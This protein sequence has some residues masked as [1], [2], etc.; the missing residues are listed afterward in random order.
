MP[1]PKKLAA[2]AHMQA[3]FVADVLAMETPPLAKMRRVER[4]L[5]AEN[6]AWRDR[7]KRQGGH[8][9]TVTFSP[10]AWDYVQRRRDMGYSR[11][12]QL[13]CEALLN[14]V[15]VLPGARAAIDSLRGQI[16]GDPTDAQV[17]SLATR[18][19]VKHLA[20]S[21]ENTLQI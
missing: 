15:E 10:A 17:V 21:Q 5:I 12:S 19:L 3:Q 16:A 2:P 13:V 11:V 7:T 18:W 20:E 14:R 6:Q 9:T 4:D 1:V 8:N